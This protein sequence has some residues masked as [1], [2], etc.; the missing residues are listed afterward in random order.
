MLLGLLCSQEAEKE[1]MGCL[2]NYSRLQVCLRLSEFVTSY[3][4][5][6]LHDS[7]PALPGAFWALERL[8]ALHIG[9]ATPS[10]GSGLPKELLFRTPGGEMR[11]PSATAHS[12]SRTPPSLPSRPGGPGPRTPCWHHT[13]RLPVLGSTSAGK[14]GG[15]FPGVKC[16]LLYVMSGVRGWTW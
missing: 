16:S 9:E 5:K 11:S 7:Q 12:P 3:S 13:H 14:C 10:P 1:A 4:W 15:G 2:H 8:L 6:T